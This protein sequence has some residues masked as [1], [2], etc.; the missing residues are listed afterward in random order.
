M[1]RVH[2]LENPRHVEWAQKIEKLSVNLYY[3]FNFQI[4]QA[5]AGHSYPLNSHSG[6][7]SSSIQ[8]EYITMVNIYALNTVLSLFLLFSQKTPK[9]NY[10]CSQ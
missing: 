8:A 5:L 6:Y 3:S 9:K 2:P 10:F 1:G 7:F 4:L